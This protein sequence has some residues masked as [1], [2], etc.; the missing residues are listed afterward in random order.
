VRLGRYFALKKAGGMEIEF[1]DKF[2]DTL[3]R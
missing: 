1:S 2:S 3:R